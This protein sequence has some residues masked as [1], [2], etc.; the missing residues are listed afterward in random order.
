VKVL[1]YLQA[2]KAVCTLVIMVDN[3]EVVEYEMLDP[4]CLAEMTP[5]PAPLLLC[6]HEPSII[7]EH[8]GDVDR[9]SVLHR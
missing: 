8:M 7:S 1:H 9:Q 3:T 6:G 5:L 2:Q 4:Q